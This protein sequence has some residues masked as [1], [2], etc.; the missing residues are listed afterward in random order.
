MYVVIGIILYVCVAAALVR[1][2]QE[3]HQRD[4][5]IRSMASPWHG[6]VPPH[7]ANQPA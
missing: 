3:I 2:F 1:I 6:E 7:N 4:E 5:E